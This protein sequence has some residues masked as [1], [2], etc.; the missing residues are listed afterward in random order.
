MF[1]M[2]YIATMIWWIQASQYSASL[3]RGQ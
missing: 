2:L 3:P 1:Y